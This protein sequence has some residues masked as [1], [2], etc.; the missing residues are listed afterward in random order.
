MTATLCDCGDCRQCRRAMGFERP[1]PVEPVKLSES[2][3]RLL[4][5]LDNPKPERTESKDR[6]KA[7]I[8]HRPTT[9]RRDY[10]MKDLHKLEGDN[11]RIVKRKDGRVSRECRECTRER[12]RAQRGSMPHAEEKPQP[13]PCIECG[14][15]IG[16]RRNGYSG[17]ITAG[18]DGKCELCVDRPKYEAFLAKY[19][20]MTPAQRTAAV[21]IQAT[22]A[23]NHLT[24][25]LKDGRPF[26]TESPGHGRGQSY[27]KYGCRCEPCIA[28]KTEDNRKRRVVAS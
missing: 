26:H 4:A 28:W 8:R 21:R 5:D 24:R 15:M 6:P 27:L 25:V 7:V 10:C 9:P 12:V 18:S 16:A 13:V 20:Q 3:L 23:R 19:D 11:L 17:W 14:E 2:T 1:A 22:R